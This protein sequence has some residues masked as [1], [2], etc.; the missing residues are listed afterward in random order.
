MFLDGCE[1]HLACKVVLPW[2]EMSHPKLSWFVLCCYVPC[3]SMLP[4][5]HHHTFICSCAQL[6]R[7]MWHVTTVTTVAIDTFRPAAGWCLPGSASLASLQQLCSLYEGLACSAAGAADWLLHVGVTW[8]STCHLDLPQVGRQQPTGPILIAASAHVFVWGLAMRC[9]LLSASHASVCNHTVPMDRTELPNGVL[10]QCSSHNT[11]SSSDSIHV[12]QGLL[13][14]KQLPASQP[15]TQL[16]TR[17][18]LHNWC[19]AGR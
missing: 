4:M 14:D 15:A 1:P 3:D 12:M 8:A 11:N 19:V 9:T 7:T 16:G 2:V 13:Q 18:L 5:Q 10:G 6:H 17:L